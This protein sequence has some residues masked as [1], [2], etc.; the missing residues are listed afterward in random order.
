M[1]ATSFDP[2]AILNDNTL[3]YSF[4]TSISRLSAVLAFYLYDILLKM[5]REIELIWTT[6]PKTTTFLYITARYATL[7]RLLIQVLPLQ[8]D[9]KMVWAIYSHD[10]RI[11]FV[12]GLLSLA[13]VIGE[14]LEVVAST[15]Y[16][17]GPE[18]V[19][20]EKTS[21]LLDAIMAAIVMLL[22]MYKLR[23]MV[24]WAD[25]RESIRSFGTKT[26]CI[27][28]DLVVSECKRLSFFS[29]VFDD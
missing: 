5:P 21:I 1:S 29:L 17:D 24:D 19:I 11:I 8:H 14:V 9:A 16:T 10:R 20:W 25:W 26:Q 15:C 23:L 12:L 7:P 18:E 22:S 28:F 6:R 4:L 27:Y 13:V 3:L 2:Q